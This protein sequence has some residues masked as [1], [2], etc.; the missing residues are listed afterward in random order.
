MDLGQDAQGRA[1]LQRVIK[2]YPN[3]NAARLAQ[4]RLE[5]AKK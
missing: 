5:P 1:T 4:Q 3:S 2:T